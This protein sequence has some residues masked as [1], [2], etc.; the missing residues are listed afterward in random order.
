M[1][2]ASPTS[3]SSHGQSACRR[4]RSFVV[5]AG[6]L[7][8]GAAGAALGVALLGGPGGLRLPD[9]ALPTRPG[10]TAAA[11]ARCAAA[12][13]VSQPA[14]D[15]FADSLGT[16]RPRLLRYARLQLRNDAWGEDAVSETLL[17]A[18]EKPEAFAGRARPLTWL[19]GILKHKIVD[20][21]RRRARGAA[22]WRR[23]RRGRRHR[24]RAARRHRPLRPPPRRLGRPRGEPGRA[25]VHRRARHLRREAAGAP[26]PRLPEREWLELETEEICSDLLITANNLHVMMHRARLRLCECLQLNR[27]GER[28]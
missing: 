1:P 11:S 20:Q 27:F 25:P 14:M 21:L 13:P 8:C 2:S 28:K 9:R 17:A 23:R 26:G 4:H 18:L 22:R 16:L 3:R 15:P 19:V 24:G 5:C 6:R 12:I 7:C 10:L